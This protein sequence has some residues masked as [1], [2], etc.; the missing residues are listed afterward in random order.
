VIAL[1]HGASLFRVHDVGAVHDALEVA[2]AT[3]S[4]R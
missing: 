2:A 1:L 3:V 4:Q